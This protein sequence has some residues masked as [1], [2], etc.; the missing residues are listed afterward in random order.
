MSPFIAFSVI[1]AI[2]HALPMAWPISSSVSICKIVESISA[3]SIFLR[4]LTFFW[5]F[6]S[7]GTFSKNNSTDSSVTSLGIPSKVISAA[8]P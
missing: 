2:S 8:I 7:T 1:S 6:L 5:M 3:K 4:R